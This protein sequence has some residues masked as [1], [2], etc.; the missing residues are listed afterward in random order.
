MPVCLE[1]IAGIWCHVE[2]LLKPT[3]LSDAD[4]W[5]VQ[6]VLRLSPVD[7]GQV[8]A[9]VID[10]DGKGPKRTLEHSSSGP[11]H[12]TYTP[13]NPN[14]QNTDSGVQIVMQVCFGA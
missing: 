10:S 9:P 2:E 4:R 6:R 14:P 13:E 5:P 11:V 3:G 1:P 8:Q 12:V 7:L